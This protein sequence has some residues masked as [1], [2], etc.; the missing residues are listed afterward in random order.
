MGVKIL[1]FGQ[2]PSPRSFTTIQLEQPAIEFNIV[3]GWFND[4]K[5]RAP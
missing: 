1:D 2:T 3:L 5:T 4:V